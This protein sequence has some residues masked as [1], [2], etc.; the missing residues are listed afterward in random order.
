MSKLDGTF[1]AS[2]PIVLILIM[3]GCDSSGGG[4][5]TLSHDDVYR[6]I[7]TVAQGDAAATTALYT[8]DAAILPPNRPEIR[9]DAIRAFW[10]QYMTF[11]KFNYTFRAESHVTEVRGDLAVDQGLYTIRNIAIGRDIEKGKYMNVF[12]RQAGQW[13]IWRTMWSPNTQVEGIFGSPA[14]G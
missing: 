7:N 2:L 6:L 12:R 5:R 8:S 14:A 4:G 13:K 9:G 11:N 1:I 3:T 10:D